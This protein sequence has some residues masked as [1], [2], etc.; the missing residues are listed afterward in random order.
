MVL[1]QQRSGHFGAFLI[2]ARPTIDAKFLHIQPPGWGYKREK[3]PESCVKLCDTLLYAI[4]HQTY[5][6]LAGPP[7]YSSEEICQQ[8]TK[9]PR[10]RTRRPCSRL[11]ERALVSSTGFEGCGMCK[12]ARLEL[13]PI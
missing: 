2:L 4:I 11:Y 10:D 12:H 5:A 1:L 3:T 9:R 13:V 8:C 6:Q 7:R